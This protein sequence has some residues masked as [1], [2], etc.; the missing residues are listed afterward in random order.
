MRPRRRWVQR[1]ELIRVSFE[2][3]VSGLL[4]DAASGRAMRPR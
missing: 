3:K 4:V 1:L 2:M